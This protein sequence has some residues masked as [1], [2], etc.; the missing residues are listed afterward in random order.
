M[1]K[2]KPLYIILLGL[3]AYYLINY[4]LAY[5]VRIFFEDFVQQS[6]MV[7]TINGFLIFLFSFLIGYLLGYSAKMYGVVFGGLLILSPTLIFMVT[8]MY[9]GF[10]LNAEQ[11]GISN[12]SVL[13]TS[14]F[15]FSFLFALLSSIL[16]SILGSVLGALARKR[17][18]KND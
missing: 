3:V 5:I 9:W 1:I 12:F 14:I 6:L 11:V 7:A 16:V 2:H 8:M 18:I 15:L 17:S 4:L 10:V 13:S